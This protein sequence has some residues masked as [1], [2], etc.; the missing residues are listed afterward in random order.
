[1][2]IPQP[3][4]LTFDPAS[5]LKGAFSSQER[6]R[7]GFG[8]TARMTAS[9][10]YWY[11]EQIGA[12]SYEARKLNTNYLPT[13]EVVRLSTEKFL[14][15]FTPEIT[16]YAEKVRP[17]MTEVARTIERGDRLRDEGRLYSAE[18]AYDE[19]LA[20]DENNVRATFGLGLTFLARD[21]AP[22]AKAVFDRLVELDAAYETRHKHMFNEFGIA[23]RKSTLFDEAL[24][25]YFRGVELGCE[26]EHLLF[27]IARVYFEKHDWAN[28]AKYLA[29]CLET[30]QAV[31]EA[32]QFCAFILA[33][34]AKPEGRD[35]MDRAAKRMNIDAAYLLN[36]LKVAAHLSSEEAELRRSRLRPKIEN[37]ARRQRHLLETARAAEE[38]QPPP[39]PLPEDD[40]LASMDQHIHSDDG[41]DIFP[42]PREDEL[43]GLA[44]VSQGIVQPL[45]PALIDDPALEAGRSMDAGLDLH[46]LL[47]DPMP[48]SPAP[49][50]KKKTKSA[51]AKGT[52]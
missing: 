30:N 52:P 10:I 31:E 39:A 27:N 5:A 11:V 25:Y 1:M 46:P 13:D 9:T 21:D 22:R 36:R 40:L 41:G 18:E 28:C 19:V 49:R 34:S 43:A 35:I 24:L 44:Q 7:L 51:P 37:A 33:K 6:V 38:G 8:G 4:A 47:L 3:D 16:L 23:L 26:D 2:A 48:E 29:L 14:I 32:R 15:R 45:A 20:V 17:A 12:D 50:T 42:A